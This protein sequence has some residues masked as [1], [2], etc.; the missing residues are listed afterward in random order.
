MKKLD[1]TDPIW[2]LRLTYTPCKSRWL[3][4]VDG[5]DLLHKLSNVHYAVSASGRTVT[6][7]NTLPRYMLLTAHYRLNIQPKK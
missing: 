4:T 6:Y 1:T 3:F 5:F 7:S 2:N